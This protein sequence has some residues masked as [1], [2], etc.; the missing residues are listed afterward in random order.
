MFPLYKNDKK[1]IISLNRIQ[2]DKI[3][4]LIENIENGTLKLIE[5]KCLCNNEL[6]PID[7]VISEK[8]RYGIPVKNIICSKCGIIRSKQI[9]D[10]KSNID[11]YTSY[12]RDI[13]VGL[14]RPD[15]DFFQNQIS[16]GKEFF[17]LFERH[18]DIEKNGSVIEVGCG[19]GG[20]LY[21]FYKKGF[22]CIGVDY[23]Q[24]Y[25]DFGKTKGLNLLNGDYKDLIQDESAYLLILSHVMEHF[26]QPIHEMK[27]IIKKVKKTGYLIVE[28]PG[29]F[30]MNKVYLNPILYLQ[31]A[32][33]YNYYYDYL[34]VFFEKLG[35][36][37]VYG[38][39]RCTFILRKPQKWEEQDINFI[40]DDAMSTYPNKIKKFILTTHLLYICSLSPYLWRQRL[41]QILTALGIKDCIKNIIN[42]IK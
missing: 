8:D 10:E 38:D 23:N 37:V 40:Y 9:F 5:N 42:A 31:N 13:Y 15:D 12:Y 32:H 25:L 29:I 3:K 30:Y 34:K 17:L 1:S 20:I 11:F 22:D 7:V 24:E 27:S 21:P 4:L 35:L 18:V 2:M 26:T 36:E 33:I 14:S 16:R 39:E 19:S 28:V 41:V 6:N